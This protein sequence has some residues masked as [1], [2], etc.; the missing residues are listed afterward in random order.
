MSHR[1]RVGATALVLLLALPLAPARGQVLVA[2]AK[3]VLRPPIP[4]GG[5]TPPEPVLVELRLGQVAVRTV[6]AFRRGDDALLPVLQFLDLAGIAAAI[7]PTGRLES[8]DQP[9]DRHIRVDPESNTAAWGSRLMSL[10]PSELVPQEGELYLAASRLAELLGLRIIV[11][12]SELAV[13]VPDPSSLPVAQRLRRQAARAALERAEA[14]DQTEALAPLSRPAWD[15][16]VL[17]YSI[18]TPSNDP[19]QGSAYTIGAGADLLGGSLELGLQSVGGAGTGEVRFDGSWLGVWRGNRWLRQLRVGDG[20]ATGPRIRALRGLMLTNAPF[21]RPSF[22]GLV[23]FAGRLAPGWEV[24]AYRGGE[25]VGFDSVG[26]GGRFALELPI[27]YGQN[28]VDL[29]AYG[30]EGQQR[31]FNRTY[32]VSA[33]LLAAHRFEYGLSAGQC[34]FTTCRATGNLDLRYGITSRLTV[35][36]GGDQLWRDTLPSLFHPY[37]SATGSLTNAWTL[38]GELVGRGLARAGVT[39]E[40]SL[41]VSASAEYTRFDAATASPLVN[42]LGRRD[43]LALTAFLRPIARLDAT[44]LEASAEHGH[45]LTGV[46]DRAR[47][48][49]SLPIGTIRLLPYARLERDGTGDGLTVSRSY[50]GLN[51]FIL[52]RPTWG[53]FL[54]PMWARTSFEARGLRATSA[55]FV[56]ARPVVAGVRLE[57]GLS[58][59]E[60]APGPTYTLSLS[61]LLRSLRAFTTATAP[62]G[63]P[64]SVTQLVQGSVVWDRSAGGLAFTPGPSLQ[65]AGVAGRV[66]LD[67][68]GNGLWDPGEPGLP[69]VRVQV[70]AGAAYS[71]SSGVYRVWDI[72]PFEPAAVTVDSM[73]FQSPLWVATHTGAVLIP[74]P[75]RF[76]RYDVPLVVGATIDGRVVRAGD[77]GVGGVGLIL[78]E[79]RSHVERRLTTFSDGVFYAASVPP[80]DYELT[81]D[82]GALE[83]LGLRAAPTRFVIGPAGTGAPEELTVGLTP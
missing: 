45:T 82:P 64:A 41:R 44:Y 3:G 25:L 47:I 20:T 12:W 70:G 80:G 50:W 23:P 69:G 68:N 38:Q 5:E 75:N 49:A 1:T 71:D 60:G 79:R 51:S 21:V 48:G 42:P 6:P 37:V 19:L 56:V 81:V 63:A 52:P 65:R 27:L 40:P 66:F 15:G 13:S 26:A 9:R 7:G 54:R 32:R 2:T 28:P 30:P 35:E 11:D 16:L 72:L 33:G 31:T 55:A 74:G 61:S 53:G 39:F 62:T 18:L 46:T 78:A 58:W 59:F 24:E 57:A 34:R 83:R 4:A 10:D 43:Q 8:I 17:D 22:L 73:S 29:M 14:A 67:Q 77:V 36:A 76:T